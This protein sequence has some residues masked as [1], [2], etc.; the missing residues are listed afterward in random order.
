[1]L[2]PS[3]VQMQAQTQ[4]TERYGGSWKFEEHFTV[5]WMQW[6]APALRVNL[7]P[8][9]SNFSY[10]AV[11]H[12]VTGKLPLMLNCFLTSYVIFNLTI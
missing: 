5:L 7:T 8:P 6:A 12:M 3:S 9:P 4:L 1:M 2:L 10:E 11:V